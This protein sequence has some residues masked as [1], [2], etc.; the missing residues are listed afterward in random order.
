V[1]RSG[2]ADY[3][4]IAKGLGIILVVIFHVRRGILEAG[5]HIGNPAFAFADYF[6]YLFHMP[7]FFLI[8]GIFVQHSLRKGTVPFLREKLI[9]IY[10]PYL[11]WS[12]VSLLAAVVLSSYV[13]N[14][15]DLQRLL[16]VPFLPKFHF[17]FLFTLMLYFILC[18]FVRDIRVLGVIAVLGSLLYLQPDVQL[19]AGRYVHFLI[20]FVAGMALSAQLQ[21]FDSDR[22][23]P[24]AL[25]VLLL[26]AIAGFWFGLDDMSPIM[27][28]AGFAGSYLVI[29]LSLRIEAGRFGNLFRLLGEQSLAIYLLHI[30]A[31]SGTR[32]VVSRLVHH[33]NPYV[34]LCVSVIAGLLLPLVAYKIAKQFRILTLSGLGKDKPRGRILH[35]ST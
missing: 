32:I 4:D 33:M 21:N 23:W 1:T 27:V 7:L 3:L 31:S 14:S 18:A 10:W 26:S 20:F 15:V 22:W 16:L 30:L 13:N 19:Y 12:I 24:G 11:L 5:G 34:L 8:S 28:P 35:A 2:R 6:T 25:A 29:A 9:H 17:W